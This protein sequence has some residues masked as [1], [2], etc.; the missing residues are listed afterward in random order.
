VK[1]IVAILLAFPLAGCFADQRQ[2][3]AACKLEALRLYPTDRPDMGH[4]PDE[5]VVADRSIYIQMCTAAHGYEYY[6]SQSACGPRS[7]S[8]S[9]EYC[10]APFGWVQ[11]LI[12]RIET[13]SRL[14]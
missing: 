10:Y 12:Y 8:S 9:N 14:Q 6:S 5:N 1:R 3:A 11:R 4:L 13:G 2:Q 7:S